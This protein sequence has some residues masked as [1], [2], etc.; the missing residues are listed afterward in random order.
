MSSYLRL[1]KKV[2]HKNL[3][4]HIIF[5]VTATCNMRC[6]MCFYETYLNQSE[7]E[8][9]LEEITK[10]SESMPPFQWLQV[11]GGETFLRKDLDKIIGLF[12]RNNKTQFFNIPTNGFYP[13][14]ILSLGE[15]MLKENPSAFINIAISILGINDVHDEITGIKGSFEKAIFSYQKLQELQKKY[16]NLGLSFSVNQN[17][18][19]ENTVK[20]LFHYLIDKCDAKQ[21]S[22][23]FARGAD[24]ENKYTD[25]S[26]ELYRENL[27]YL[28]N[29]TKN[30][31]GYYFN[32][33]LKTFFRSVSSL[34]KDISYEVAMNKKFVTPC[35]AGR[36]SAVLT[37]EG[38]FYSCEMR[39]TAL[40]NFRESNYD[41]NA[42]WN[43]E[44]AE[45]ERS[46][47]KDNKCFCTHDCFLNTNIVFNPGIYP[48]LAKKWL[49]QV[50]Q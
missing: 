20:E 13:D 25:T 31:E 38:D 34:Q 12:A 32:M 10:I 9:T 17:S 5:F 19:N 6:S 39:K 26:P 40:G 42:I 4:E 2:F 14:R 22:F 48:R 3:P 24:I 41:F 23:M 33:P 27:T 30:K 43:S 29:L 28:N 50:A 16:P 46:D 44:T 45:Q 36:L 1:A 49:S 15:N 21:I 37:E 8:L 11:S 18:T 7:N 35:Y 47:I